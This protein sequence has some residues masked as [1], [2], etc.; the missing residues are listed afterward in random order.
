MSTIHEIESAI[1]KQRPEE[2]HAVADWLLSVLEA[3]RGAARVYAEENERRHSQVQ[4]QAPPDRR[5]PTSQR[6]VRPKPFQV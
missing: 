3:M 4:R 5:V 6:N 1:T 2:V